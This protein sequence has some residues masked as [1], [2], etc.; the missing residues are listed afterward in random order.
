MTPLQLDDLK[1]GQTFISDSHVLDEEQIK[2][3]ARAFEPQPFHLDGAAAKKNPVRRLG[4]Q[5]LAYCRNHH[6][7]ERRVG[8]AARQ[9]HRAGGEI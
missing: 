5:R 2:A 6:A 8:P 7:A 1:P 4:R 3:F 9:R